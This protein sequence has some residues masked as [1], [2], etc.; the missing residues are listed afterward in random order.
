MTGLTRSFAFSCLERYAANIAN[1]VMTAV[2]ARLLSPA[3][4]GVF[5]VGGTVVLLGEILR[6][7]GASTYLI[8]AREITPAGVR[9][10]FTLT[11]LL[12]VGLAGAIF[13]SAD[14]LAAFYGDPRLAPVLAVTAA[15]F[16]VG[17]FIN[18]VLALLRREMAFDKVALINTIGVA[19][20][21]VTAIGLAVAGFGYLSLA[22][23][24]LVS[25]IA[26]AAA[27]AFFRPP[28]PV[29]RLTLADW[30]RVFSFGSY[31]SATALLN[32]I[33]QAWPQLVLGRILGF[34][35]VGLYSR[36]LMLV[37]MPERSLLAAL[38]PVV[39][40]ALAAEARRGG[41]LR[42]PYIQA[43]ALATAVQWPFLISL[44]ILAEPA[45]RVVLG[46]AWAEAASVVRL[47]ALAS[48][49]LF[50]GFLTYPT[51]V[52]VGRVRD[53]LTSSLI[54][55][56]PSALL[57]TLAAFHGLD[58]V[59]ASLFV[60]G[61]F[62]AAV[63]FAFIRRQLPFAWRD[64][65]VAL[66]RSALVVLG[67]GAA[68]L[69]IAWSHGFTPDLSAGAIALAVAGGGAGWLIA[70]R[71]SR[72]PLLDLVLPLIPIAGL[73]RVLIRPFRRGVAW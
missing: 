54:V 12:S 27:A 73:K 21:L 31:A 16:L 45:V 8:Q 26:T 15:G 32:N 37:Q 56:P 72:H 64:L 71:L 70:L 34:D 55:L 17:P 53:T 1:L 10:T 68:P 19:A 41:D 14:S 42:A 22:F 33:Y 36:A 62:Q 39:L 20:N 46:P 63:T 28:Y 24:Y 67:T 50:A 13:G 58:W 40:P 29:F 49:S 65:A 2:L 3:E 35:A 6:D 7:F 5:V 11:L 51:L 30:R 44:A 61:P 9:T 23:A 47:M 4:I 38:Q 69:A 48:F 57:V 25:V 18:P 59:A 43:I 60:I 66:E 52:A